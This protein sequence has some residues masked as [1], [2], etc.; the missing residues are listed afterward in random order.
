MTLK[1]SPYVLYADTDGNVFE[2][3]TLYAVGR[4]GWYCDPIPLEDWI[5]L[6]DGGSLYNLPGRIPLGIDVNTGEMR[7]CDKGLA[8]AA[9]VPPAHTGLYLA[10][11][12]NQPEAPILSL[13]CY[14][15]VGWHRGKFYVPAIRVEEDIRQECAGFDHNVVQQGVK[16]LRKAYP[17]NRLVEHLAENCALTYTC[18]ACLLRERAVDP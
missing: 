7:L 3:K 5:E 4:S 12:E 10:A 2:D 11:Y 9:F 16:E 18:P 15:A 6:P 1:H 14:T 13:F 17:H 8:V